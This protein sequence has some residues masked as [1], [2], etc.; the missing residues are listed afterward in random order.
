MFG[1]TI[2]GAA[3]LYRDLNNSYLMIKLKVTDAGGANLG[4]NDAVAPSNLPLHTMFSNV[5]MTICGR[6]I[7]EKDSNYPYRAYLET[8]LTF[9]DTVLKTRALA[10]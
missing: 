2:P 5:S 3:D 7:S 9:D 10:E 8:L 4:A 6:E 1:F